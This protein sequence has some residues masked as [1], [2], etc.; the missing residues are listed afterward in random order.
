MNTPF[1]EL[2]PA[3]QKMLLFGT[4]EDGN[5]KASAGRSAKGPACKPFEGIIDTAEAAVRR[6]R[7]LCH[8]VG[9]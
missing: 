7:L 2:K 9:A 4:G 1:K 6:D 3:Q 5:G 8:A